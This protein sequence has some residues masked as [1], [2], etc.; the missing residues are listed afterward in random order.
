MTFFEKDCKNYEE[1]SFCQEKYQVKII[2]IDIKEWLNIVKCITDKIIENTTMEI[3]ENN[4]K[5]YNW[6]E[7]CGFGLV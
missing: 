7:M 3:V 5:C 6:A 1:I 2:Q 4:E